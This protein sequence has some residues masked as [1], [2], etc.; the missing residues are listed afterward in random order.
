MTG[1]LQDQLFNDGKELG[2]P[3]IPT[4]KAVI[5]SQAVPYIYEDRIGKG[6]FLSALSKIHYM[7]TE[8]RREWGL[9]GHQHVVENFGFKAFNDSWIT[10]MDSVY[11]NHGSW[12]TRKNYNGITLLEVA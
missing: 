1:G 9:E 6:Q 4:S 8:D 11:E 12:D 3:L 10:L 2:V 7:S 5:G